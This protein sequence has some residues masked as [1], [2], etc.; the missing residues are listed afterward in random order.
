[1]KNKKYIILL[2]SLIL[3]SC[4]LKNT[5][6]YLGD[7]I[8]IDEERITTLLKKEYKNLNDEFSNNNFVMKNFYKVLEKDGLN[9]KT[10]NKISGLLKKT[11]KII[12]N[13][14]NYELLRLINT[15]NYYFSYDEEIIKNNKELFDYYFHQSLD[16][17]TTYTN[18]IIVLGLY[19][20]L[21]NKNYEERLN[22]LIRQ[23]NY[24]IKQI[25]DEYNVKYINVEQLSS[26][27]YEDNHL[28]M[29]GYNYF[30]KKLK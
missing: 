13:I 8:L 26:F 28:N 24:L 6:L 30:L 19:N 29:N 11:N 23:Y 3:N 5:I 15:N 21:I 10:S 4:N 20:S 2:T 9:L 7:N 27:I 1:M 18:N 14:G 12:F 17:L 25:S 16:I 22:N